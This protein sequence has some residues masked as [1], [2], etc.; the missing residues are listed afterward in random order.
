M[1]TK[2]KTTVP[3]PKPQEYFCSV[4]VCR[5]LV[6]KYGKDIEEKF[7]FLI[8]PDRE[9]NNESFETIE[10]SAYLDDADPDFMVN[11]NENKEIATLLFKE[12]KREVMHF[13]YWW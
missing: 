10:V 3:K 6:S 1:A 4:D 12:F 11:Q 13:H 2:K 9:V 7:H 5:F 8:N